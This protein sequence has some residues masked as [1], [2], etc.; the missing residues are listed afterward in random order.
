MTDTQEIKKPRVHAPKRD[1]YLRSR[2]GTCQFL[3]IRCSKCSGY[4]ALYQKD[5]PGDLLRLYLDRIF[6]PTS[7]VERCATAAKKSDYSGLTCPKCRQLIG[8]PMI[9]EP[10]NRLAFRLIKGRFRK[11][12]SNGTY[13]PDE[14]Q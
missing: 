5:G 13:I 14:G 1:K 4:V 7:L 6:E 9:Y 10:E 12:K 8:V 3:I 11:E 2:G